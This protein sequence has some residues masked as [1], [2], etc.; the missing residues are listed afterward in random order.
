MYNFFLVGCIST[1]HC[2][3]NTEVSSVAHKHS[4][5]T[6]KLRL[7]QVFATVQSYSFLLYSNLEKHKAIAHEDITTLIN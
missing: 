3:A 7:L 4:T 5:N 2:I 6:N 1:A